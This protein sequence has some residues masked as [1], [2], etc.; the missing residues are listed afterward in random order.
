MVW[1]STPNSLQILE[2]FGDFL[3]IGLLVNRG[4]GANHESR[5]F[6]GPDA[7]DGLPEHPFAL[8]A[9]IVRCL[10]AVQVNVEEETARWV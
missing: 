1:P 8:D 3:Q 9:K 7:V 5:V 10:H 2:E 4:V 6:G